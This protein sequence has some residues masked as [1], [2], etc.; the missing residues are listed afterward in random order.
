MHMPY[1]HLNALVLTRCL[2]STDTI[3]DSDRILVLSAGRV[4]EFD[5]P[6]NLIEKKDS[7]FYSLVKEAGLLEPGNTTA[8]A[9]S[10]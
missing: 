6:K 3:I 2:R 9:P 1:C 10:S 4:A 8:S 5:T 7:L